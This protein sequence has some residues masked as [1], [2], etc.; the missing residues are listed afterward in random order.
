MPELSPF[1]ARLAAGLRR[2]ADGADTRVDAAEVARRAMSRRRVGTFTWLGLPL[3]IPSWI[4]LLLGLLLLTLVGAVVLGGSRGEDRLA[5]APSTSPAATGRP[6]PTPTAMP[7]TDGEGDEVVFGTET[8]VQLSRG[9]ASATSAMNDF[10]VSG[11]GT[12]RFSVDRY[13]QVSSE[14]GTFRLENVAGAWEGTCTGAIWED[15]GRSVVACWLLGSGD[16]AGYTYYRIHRSMTGRTA[17]FDVEGVIFPGS[18]PNL[19]DSE[20]P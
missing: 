4:V 11:S 13:D 3:P 20:V 18:P 7:A 2:F 1:E 16:Y 17:T 5:V 9:V 10:R 8:Q 19:T 6:A 15:G 14:S 12:F